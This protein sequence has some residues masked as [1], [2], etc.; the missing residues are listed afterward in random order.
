MIKSNNNQSCYCR[1]FKSYRE[2]DYARSGTEALQ[3]VV[4]EPGPLKEFSHAMEPQLRKLGLPTVLKRGV[5]TLE[6]DYTVCNK[7]SILTPEQAQILV[8]T[9]S[10]YIFI[11]IWFCVKGRLVVLAIQKQIAYISELSYSVYSNLCMHE[12]GMLVLCI[13]WQ[14]SIQ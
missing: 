6:R 13:K 12:Y 8:S 14:H 2:L 4:L 5:I 11:I 9:S 3:T 7:G 1:W 10:M